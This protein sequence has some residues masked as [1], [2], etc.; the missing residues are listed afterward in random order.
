MFNDAVM[1]FEN[2]IQDEFIDA[3]NKVI[4]EWVDNPEWTG[5]FKKFIK[6][7]PSKWSI[8]SSEEESYTAA[9]FDWSFLQGDQGSN[10]LV[11]LC[12][13]SQ[14]EMGFTF[15][16]KHDEFGGKLKWSK[17]CKT[18]PVSISSGLQALGFSDTG[19]GVFSISIRLNP[20]LLASSWENENYE[21]VMQPVIAVL[22]NIKQSVPIFDEMFSLAKAAGLA[23]V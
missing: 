23:R 14:N 19:L 13:F 2:E 10:Y 1:L 21:E 20:N 6:I 15:C 9:T 16:V 8:S 5:D 18:L 3:L 22:E 4:E 11:N 17:F 12:G 7:Y